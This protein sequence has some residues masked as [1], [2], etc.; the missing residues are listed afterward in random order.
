MHWK[1]YAQVQ[2]EKQDEMKSSESVQTYFRTP[3]T[4]PLGPSRYFVTEKI[5]F[6]NYFI[7]TEYFHFKYC[8][9]ILFL[10]F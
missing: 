9:N 5:I 6:I 8:I 1:H 10:L 4:Q 2:K 3:R 7:E